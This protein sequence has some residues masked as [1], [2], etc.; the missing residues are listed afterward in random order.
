MS[1][2]KP[3]TDKE[4]LLA[5]LNQSPIAKSLTDKGIT[6]DYLATLLQD[7]LTATDVKIFQY[8]G[9]I[10]KSDPLPALEIRQRARIDAHK[11]MDHYPAE[12]H[13]VDSNL[14]VEVIDYKNLGEKKEDPI[15]QK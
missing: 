6:P 3:L 13:Q 12:R 5:T 2:E 14:T 11:L 1:E 15:P 10:V 4:K 7:E 9:Q 8:K